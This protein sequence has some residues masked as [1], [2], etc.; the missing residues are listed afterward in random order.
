[1]NVGISMLLVLS[2]LH[3]FATHAFNNT[4]N[5]HSEGDILVRKARWLPLIYPRS[6]PTR[7]QVSKLWNHFLVENIVN[8]VWI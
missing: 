3:V 6:N 4:Q 5:F 7:L 1:M 8:F 2:F